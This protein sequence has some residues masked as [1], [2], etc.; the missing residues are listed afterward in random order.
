MFFLDVNS[1]R[2]AVVMRSVGGRPA[3]QQR[4]QV[5]RSIPISGKCLEDRPEFL[6]MHTVLPRFGCP[7]CIDPHLQDV[8]HRLQAA[9]RAESVQ[10]IGVRPTMTA[11]ECLRVFPVSSMRIEEICGVR[12]HAVRPPRVFYSGVCVALA[13]SIFVRSR[14]RECIPPPR[15]SSAAR[16]ALRESRRTRTSSRTESGQR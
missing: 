7:S 15:A 13:D 14:P 8:H 16:S 5:P 11:E 4:G 12:R 9:F 3:A 2:V 6:H 10:M 1:M